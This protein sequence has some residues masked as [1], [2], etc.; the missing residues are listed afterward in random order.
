MACEPRERPPP[1]PFDSMSIAP[2]QARR[3]L[4]L[5]SGVIVVLELRSKSEKDARRERDLVLHES[6]HQAVIEV[7]RKESEWS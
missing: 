1:T 5:E 6:A 2:S 7:R 3:R 4:H